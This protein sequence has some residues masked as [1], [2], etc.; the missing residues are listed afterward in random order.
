MSYLKAIGTTEEITTCDCCGRSD[1]QLTVIMSEQENG[2]ELHRFHYGRTCAAKASG[3]PVREV[4][5]EA[6]KADKTRLLTEKQEKLVTLHTAKWRAWLADYT[7]MTPIHF[8]TKTS[9]NGNVWFWFRGACGCTFT[10]LGEP[11]PEQL[12][13]NHKRAVAQQL[14]LNWAKV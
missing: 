4:W 12:D 3:R 8:D 13:R 5:A 14:G 1:L 6:Q 2:E 11:T 7:L 9:P 10:T